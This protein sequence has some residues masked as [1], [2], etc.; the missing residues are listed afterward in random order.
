M[1]QYI[2]NKCGYVDILYNNA[3]I[4]SPTKPIWEH[5]LEHW[6]HLF[7]VNLFT[8]ILLCNAFGP[9]MKQRGY[10]RIIN[11]SSGIKDQPQYAPYSVSKAAVDKYTKD[12]AFELQGSGVLANFLDP[13][14]IQTDLGGPSAPNTVE[15]VLPGALVPAL[16]EDDGPNGQGFN[17]QDFRER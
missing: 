14:W 17:A 12:L 7:Q 8:M 9:I 6:Q 5:P 15:S 11:I 4:S 13:G 2:L 10:G 1:I 16:F 3:A